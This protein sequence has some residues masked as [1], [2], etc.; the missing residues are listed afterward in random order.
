MQVRNEI[1]NY[2]EQNGCEP[3]MIFL[4][5]HGVF[6]SADEPA[7][8][9]RLYNEIMS[10]LIAKYEESAISLDLEVAPLP[11]TAKLQLSKKTICD[12]MQNPNLSIAVSGA[13]DVPAGP[14]TPDHIVYSKSYS[15]IGEP[16]VNL[17]DDF[18]AK[19]GY[20]PQVFAFNGAVFGVSEKQKSADLALE[21]AQDGSLVE[22]LAQAFGGIDYM[23]DRAREFI[24]NWEV[25]SY[26]KKQMEQ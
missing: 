9:R 5:N 25:E 22:K 12:A 3:A 7:E 24:E 17:I 13:F 1:Q 26:R 16:S 18:K 4:K 11:Q 15:F 10:K 2:K 6:V 20:A 23:T 14:I 8:I 19:H 21:L